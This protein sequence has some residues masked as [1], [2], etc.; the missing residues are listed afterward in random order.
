MEKNIIFFLIF[1]V[2]SSFAYSVDF[3][4]QGDINL[5]NIYD[6]KNAVGINASDNITSNEFCLSGTCVSSWS[7]LNASS[8]NCNVTG[9]CPTVLYNTNTS[10]IKNTVNTSVYYQ[11]KVAWA[12]ILNKFIESVDGV[13][14]Y[15]S[16]T[17]ITLNETKLNS[18]INTISD[19]VA[20]TYNSSQTTYINAQDLS[21]NNSQKVYIDN[22]NIVYNNT[23]KTYIDAQNIFYNS[24]QK[25][26]IDAQD[27]SFNDSQKVYVDLQNN[28]FNTSQKTYIDNMDAFYN[29]TQ[30]TWVK[31]NYY[32]QTNS[33]SRFVNVDGDYMRGDLDLGNYTLT[34]ISFAEFQN[35]NIS[36]LSY[37]S[38]E[39]NIFMPDSDDERHHLNVD[40]TNLDRIW[41]NLFKIQ[42]KVNTFSN[43]SGW[44][45]NITTV[46][47][48]SLTFDVAGEN[49]RIASSNLPCIRKLYNG[50]SE[51]PILNRV[52][53]DNADITNCSGITI[54]ISEPTV[55]HAM[56]ARVLIGNISQQLY[57]A[58]LLPD[59]LFGAIKKL[60]RVNRLKG[61]FYLDG[62]APEINSDSFYVG[63]GTYINTVENIE[64][65]GEVN[66]TTDGF[67]VILSTNE[68]KNYNAL[69]SV[70][71][72]STGETF[73]ANKYWIGVVGAVPY[74]GY[75]RLMLLV[76]SKPTV[77][78]NSLADAEADIYNS[79]NTFPSQDFL[80]NNFL[81]IAKIIVNSNTDLI[82]LQNNGLYYTDLRGT[83]SCDGGSAVSSGITNHNELNNLDYSV[84]GHTGFSSEATTLNKTTSFGGDVSGTYN[85][86][87]VGTGTIT[88]LEISSVNASQINNFDIAGPNTYYYANIINMSDESISYVD[89]SSL[90]L[91]NNGD[92]ATGNYTFNGNISATAFFGDGSQLTGISTTTA[93]NESV[94]NVYLA[95]TSNKVGIGKTTPNA[96]LD[97]AG[98]ISS[99]G[100]IYSNYDNTTGI[101]FGT[102]E[103]GGAFVDLVSGDYSAYQE[104]Y[105]EPNYLGAGILFSN[106]YFSGLNGKYLNMYSF[107][108]ADYI[109]FNSDANNLNVTFYGVSGVPLFIDGS[110]SKVGIGTATPSQK[111][112]VNSGSSDVTSLFQSTDANAYIIVQDS[113]TATNSVRFGA[114]T[115][116]SVLYAGGSERLRIEGLTGNV[117][118]GTSTPS[119][120]LHVQGNVNITGNMSIGSGYIYYNGTHL[121]IGG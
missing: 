83:R 50:T 45:I 17:Q 40:L 79:Q 51:N 27:I 112:N 20:L 77:E 118:I 93:W 96:S 84:S 81:P 6:I 106:I 37:Y 66:S 38:N 3:T 5:R 46:D 48:G 98:Y 34:N 54:S 107:N 2:L 18:T 103:D 29:L 113:N 71:Q 36:G 26:Y 89:G 16:G 8:S 41:A 87:Q 111:L 74:D 80:K 70:T 102:G 23:Q 4:P 22:Q 28:N 47:S 108:T 85:N 52:Y 21:Y 78:Y 33:D 9:T 69:S 75:I 24:S 11:I 120:K 63:N 15:M 43:A 31:N 109:D 116:D 49:G 55:S 64:G 86:I 76:N 92:T 32:N 119:Q 68:Y 95:T 100:G 90:F 73:G 14:L 61:L 121:I 82:Q 65:N 58:S 91:K 44:Y 56:I 42:T 60:L 13:Y 53:I 35:L 105:Y 1:V 115:N 110:N 57:G 12:N 30:K 72:Y 104:I 97:V 99:D 10:F 114:V 94:G 19:S 59:N 62:F 117:G 7:S 67:F 25:V 101:F 88:P 39:S